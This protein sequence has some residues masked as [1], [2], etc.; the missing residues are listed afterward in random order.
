[1]WWT[2]ED[3]KRTRLSDKILWFLLCTALFWVFASFFGYVYVTRCNYPFPIFMGHFS[4]FVGCLTAIYGL[5]LFHWKRAPLTKVI[6]EVNEK[7][8]NMLRSATTNEIRSQRNRI[9]YICIVIFLIGAVVGFTTCIGLI[10]EFLITGE[11]HFKNYFTADK[12]AYSLWPFM[13]C[14]FGC[15]VINWTFFFYNSFFSMVLELFLIISLNFRV[16]A[17]DLRKIK[18]GEGD[19]RIFKGLMK[20]LHDLQR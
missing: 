20:E 5:V 8:W 19:L 17:S 11:E 1:M 14:I 4:C 2:E 13:N 10:L 3:Y 7:S 12:P 16:L 6:G 9:H 15:S 18:I